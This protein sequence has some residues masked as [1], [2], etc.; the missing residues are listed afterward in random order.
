[1]QVGERRCDV[2]EAKA[3]GERQDQQQRDAIAIDPG[4][5]ACVR[6]GGP[7][8]S[9][10]LDGVQYNAGAPTLLNPSAEISVT[11]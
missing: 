6:T 10:S 7:I 1:M 3:A 11:P 9:E 5:S 8:K 4:P 2:D